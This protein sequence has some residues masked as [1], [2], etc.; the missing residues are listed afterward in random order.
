MQNSEDGDGLHIAYTRVGEKL[1][2]TVNFPVD[3]Y[4]TIRSKF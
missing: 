2:Y 1:F 4:Y 3:G